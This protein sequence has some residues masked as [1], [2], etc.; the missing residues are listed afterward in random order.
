[1]LPERIYFLD[2][3]YYTQFVHSKSLIESAGE[4]HCDVIDVQNNIWELFKKHGQF[5]KFKMQLYDR[6]MFLYVMRY[7]EIKEEFKELF[8]KKM[9]Q[10]L[11]RLRDGDFRDYLAYMRKFVFD[12]VMISQNHNDFDILKEF[13]Y[14][15]KDG[16]GDVNQKMSQSVEWFNGLSKQHK[17]FAF[18]YILEFFKNKEL[19]SL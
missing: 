5:D 10:D 18:N 19:N 1:M 17:R 3:F 7:D 9:K 15:L 12:S 2:E 16:P 6:K 14:I 4:N 8:F 11:N 13:Y